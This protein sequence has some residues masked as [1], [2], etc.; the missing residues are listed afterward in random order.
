[1]MKVHPIVA[2]SWAGRTGKVGRGGM[3]GVRCVEGKQMRAW[4]ICS[5]AAHLK[6]KVGNC[7]FFSGRAETVE[8]SWCN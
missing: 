6:Y 3:G 5:H 7:N 8:K 1:M 2:L 4:T